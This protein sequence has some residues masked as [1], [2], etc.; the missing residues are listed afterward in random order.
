MNHLGIQ[1]SC[2][3]RIWLENS[4]IRRAYSGLSLT[5]RTLKRE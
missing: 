4:S 5:V 1:G 3:G 2:K